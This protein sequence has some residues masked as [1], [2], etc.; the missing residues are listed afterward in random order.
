MRVLSGRLAVPNR[1]DWEVTL[2][3]P[4]VAVTLPEGTQCVRTQNG[5]WRL[6]Q[7][8]QVLADVVITESG[9][10]T[11]GKR[12]SFGC[13]T[14]PVLLRTGSTFSRNQVVSRDEFAELTMGDRA[15]L[16]LM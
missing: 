13:D 2:K 14:L 4:E 9:S 1:P 12:E 11:S 8:V 10:G 3:R 5:A 15:L 6:M 7:D 16:E